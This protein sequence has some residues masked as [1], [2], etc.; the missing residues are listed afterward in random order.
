VIVHAPSLARMEDL[1][2]LA[3]LAQGVVVVRTGKPVKAH[4]GPDALRALV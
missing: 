4:F 3:P 1:S 2:P